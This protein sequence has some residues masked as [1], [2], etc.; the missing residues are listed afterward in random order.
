MITFEADFS[1][2]ATK[3]VVPSSSELSLNGGVGTALV[4]GQR[5]RDLMVDGDMDENGKPKKPTS[6]SH[7]SRDQNLASAD[8]EEDD[9]DDANPSYTDMMDTIRAVKKARL[10]QQNTAWHIGASQM[11]NLW[12]INLD[13]YLEEARNLMKSLRKNRRNITR[14]EELSQNLPIMGHMFTYSGR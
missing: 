4:S 8:E 11:A 5:S 14:I 2:A 7:V 12:G 6:N 3:L 10:D 9:D 1:F 13:K